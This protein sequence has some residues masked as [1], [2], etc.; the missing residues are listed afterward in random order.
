MAPSAST[1]R[2]RCAPTVAASTTYGCSPRFLR[3]QPP[4]HM[5]A[6]A[7]GRDAQLRGV[8]PRRPLAL[9]AQRGPPA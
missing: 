4:P 6:G 2:S 5:V 9:Q 7:H 8:R 1:P 3:L